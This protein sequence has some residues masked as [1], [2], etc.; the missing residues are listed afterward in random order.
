MMCRQAYDV[1]CGLAYLHEN[2]VIHGD[3]KGVGILDLR[4]DGNRCNSV[5]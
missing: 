1:A 4:L 3:L 5:K 2:K